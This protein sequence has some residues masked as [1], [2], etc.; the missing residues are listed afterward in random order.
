MRQERHFSGQKVPQTPATS[1]QRAQ[2]AAI[3][4]QG[5]RLNGVNEKILMM[6]EE[7]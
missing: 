3:S 2:T 4:A 1:R 5:Q 6:V 7:F